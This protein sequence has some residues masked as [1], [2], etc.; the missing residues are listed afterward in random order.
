MDHDR[1]GK[2]GMKPNGSITCLLLAGVLAGMLPARATDFDARLA[3]ARKLAGQRQFQQSLQI[4]AEIET[5]L[6]RDPGLVVEMARV[7]MQA[8]RHTEAIRLFERVRDKHPEKQGAFLDELGEACLWSSQPHKAVLV[9][10]AALQRNPRDLRARLGLGRG[11]S[12]SGQREASL[13]EYDAVLQA[14]PGD[15]NA[16]NGKADALCHM[17]RLAE[18]IET[19][20]AVLQKDPDNLEAANGVARCRVWQ[21]YHRQGRDLYLEILKKHPGNLEAIEGLAFAQHWDGRDDQAVETL[22]RL[23]TFST[24]RPAAQNLRH[25]I[26][27][28]QEPYA[29]QFNRMWWDKYRNAL[30][31]HGL[32]AG[33]RLDELTAADA[34]YDWRRLQSKGLPDMHASRIGLGGSH[35]FDDLLEFNGYIYQGTYDRV[36]FHPLTANAWLTVRPDDL[37]RMDLAYARETFDMQKAAFNKIV[38]DNY[39]LS[40][41][42]KPNRWLLFS[43]KGM[44]GEYT[45]GNN[46]NSF[47][48]KAELRLCSKP[49]AKLYYNYYWSE[50]D[51]QF[52][53]GYFDPRE[54]EAH[55]L[56]L[57]TGFSITDRLFFETQASVA[58]E[59][60]EPYAENPSYFCAAG[61]NY[62]MTS[63]WNLFARAE[64]FQALP[65]HDHG[66]GGYRV[67]TLFFGITHN[68]GGTPDRPAEAS[69][70]TRPNS[71]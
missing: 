12:W 39:S 9:F 30:E 47:L 13:L 52:D 19:Y 70:P 36:D 31:L 33:L 16:N 38:V 22:A 53:H 54:F 20:Q 71:H 60:Q 15:I 55:T 34:S 25:E 65:D 42:F 56:G 10:R 7:C 23:A 37:W 63:N 43:G 68:F 27:T 41:D 6:W 62:R 4:Y 3:D 29:T 8:E 46:Q 21:G 57:Y 45:D 24:N 18:A 14:T 32:R 1:K 51:R 11:L 26:G 5:E 49:Y 35:K 66:S 50:W 17:D 2:K 48:G 40:M 58:F 59:H 69:Q 28:S 44:H 61:F 67:G 64:A